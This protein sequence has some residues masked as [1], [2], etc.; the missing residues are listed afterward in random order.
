MVSKHH[1]FYITVPLFKNTFE[2]LINPHKGKPVAFQ[3]RSG[4]LYI[5]N[6]LLRFLNYRT[7]LFGGKTATVTTTTKTTSYNLHVINN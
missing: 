3:K 2:D 6:H 1:S 4:S 7:A 5:F